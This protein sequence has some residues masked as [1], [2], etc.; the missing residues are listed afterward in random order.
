MKLSERWLREWVNPAVDSPVLADK[1]NMAGHE[2][3]AL[4]VVAELPGNVVVGCVR[5][6]S[7]HPHSDHL[8]VCKVD[9]GG[10]T[11]LSIVCGAANVDAG[12]KVAVAVAGAKL[13]GG[14]TITAA[15]IHGEASTGML[16][17]AAELGLAEHS[18]GILDLDPGAAL[19]TDIVKYLQLDD[20]ILNLELTP[21]RGDCLS[22]AGMARETA[23]IFAIP[24]TPIIVRQAVVLQ[25]SRAVSIDDAG[26]CSHYVGRA[27]RGLK[28]H[29]RTPDWMRERLRRSGIRCLHPVVD[30]TN[31]VML[32]LGQPMH[33]FDDAKLSGTVHVRRAAAGETLQL[34]DGQDLALTAQDLVIADA[35]HAVALAGI[36]GG[37]ATGVDTATHDI[38]LESACFDPVSVAKSGRMHKLLTDARHRF[39]RG[40]DPAL[41]RRALER[42]TALVLEICGGNA[43][44]VSEAGRAPAH[45]LD[46]SLR[47]TRV[48]QLLGCDIPATEIPRML[49][50]LGIETQST[51]AGAWSARVPTCRYDLEQEVDLIEEIGR[52]HGY[53]HIPARA[54]PASLAPRIP[55][56]TT[57]S[58]N[59]IRATLV[60]RGYHE[61]VT[62]SF[63]DSSL[64]KLFIADEAP[65]ALDNP[66]AATMDV[67]RMTLWCGLVATWNYN[68]QRQRLQARLF[69]AGAC[70]ARTPAGEVHE[71]QR[72]AGLI[73]GN[74]VPRQW[75]QATR[76]PDFYDIKADLD[77]V[78]GSQAGHAVCEPARHPAL[79]DGR[80]ARILLR[81]APC[82]WIGELHPK[83][84]TAL[85]LPAAPVVFELDWDTI[86]NS[87]L[88]TY[89]PLST[90]PAVRRDLALRL[91]PDIPARQLVQ[92]VLSSAKS[93]LKS[94]EVFD[95]YSDNR[96]DIALK[97]VALTLVFQDNSA[98]L[99]D[100]DVDAAI[101]D[102]VAYL[103][104]SMNVVVRGEGEQSK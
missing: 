54:S 70:F 49:G 79:H 1:L 36:M 25:T 90:Q 6:V 93:S 50:R 68:R 98:T 44:S 45:G 57:R 85:G 28:P 72:I 51:A 62:Y 11:L 67:M 16:C 81:G 73:A 59:G 52:L 78:L 47:H 24:Q 64:Q 35:R 23:A 33:A 101:Q 84:C 87:P 34:L 102:I 97:S 7:G 5:E 75:G 20:H 2:C 92:A 40:V 104:R 39:E 41:Q 18:D 74:V 88:P 95:V 66:I 8:H 21:N 10:N 27:I 3:E 86:C 69:E 96:D 83:A 82:G 42:A 91:K 46:I 65:I 53:D 29:A 4:P 58:M 48:S 22:V 63:V 76:A 37:M 89:K 26:G 60:A 9:I 103:K 12:M 38:F 43:D 77:A 71:T 17:S 13:P 19:G 32:E 99:R 100:E 55:L 14:T 15:E 30:I 31:Y 94:V 56:E 61:A 80:S